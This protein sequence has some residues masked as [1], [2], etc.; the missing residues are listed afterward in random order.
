[1]SS[2]R[3]AF[4]LDQL[5]SRQAEQAPDALAVHAA[6]GQLNYAELDAAAARIAAGLRELGVRPGDRVAVSAGKSAKVVIALYGVLR[7]GATYVPIDPLAP[8]RRALGVIAD[9][10]CRVVCGDPPRLEQLSALA[11]ELLTFSLQD[12]SAPTS[13]DGSAPTLHLEDLDSANGEGH[14]RACEADLAYILYTSGST[15]TPKGVMLTHGNALSFVEWA[16]NRF[17]VRPEDR[18]VSHAPFH[19]DLSVFDLYG[20]AM[21]CASVHLL[22]PGQEAMAGDLAAVIKERELT[23]W[24]SVPSALVLLSRAATEADL[25]TLRVILFAGEVLPMKHLRG[26]RALAPQAVLANLYGPTETNVCTYFVVEGELPPGDEPLPIGCACENQA[27]FA[28][29][30]DLREVRPGATGELWVRGPTV[31]KGYWGNP[32]ET[33]RRLRQNP[34]HDL[35]PDPAFRTGDLVRRLPDG[36]YEFLGRRDHQVKSRGYRVELGEVEVALTTH[37]HV[38]QAAVVAVPDE[39]IGSRLIGFAGVDANVDELE[40]KRHCAQ[41][42]PRYMVPVSIFVEQA[43]PQTSTGKIDREALKARAI[44]T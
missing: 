4:S 5:V 7:A 39:Q 16:V 38:Q 18:L 19:F 26:L 41:T 9:A 13:E 33:Q 17:A 24:Y 2:G 27:V 12:G 20:A 35:Y 15:G 11:P 32:E 36:N 43:L 44:A 31:M 28:L 37:P 10:Q 1:M 14:A 8:S 25:R 6:D 29:D 21:A 3:A 34:Q 40:L 22:A 23:V 30:D 42:L